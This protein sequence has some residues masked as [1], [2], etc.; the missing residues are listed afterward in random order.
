[1][2]NSLVIMISEAT[3]LLRNAEGDVRTKQIVKREL[4]SEI[5]S[6]L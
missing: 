3:R 4:G 5:V 6:F 2:D 1:M